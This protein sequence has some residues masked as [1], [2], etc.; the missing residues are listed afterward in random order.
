MVGSLR[1]QS[2]FSDCEHTEAVAY[3]QAVER[4][5]REEML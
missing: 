4:K 2:G 1:A 5:S 3:C